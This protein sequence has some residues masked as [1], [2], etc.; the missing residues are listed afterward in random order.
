MEAFGLLPMS[1]D[2]LFDLSLNFNEADSDQAIDY[3]ICPNCHIHM[4]VRINQYICERCGLL[5]ENIEVADHTSS[6]SDNSYSMVASGIRCIGTNAYRYH[7]ILRSSS[8]SAESNREA[9]LSSVLFNF[10]SNKN[11]IIPKEVLLSVADQYRYIVQSGT[12]ARGT[13]FRAML[14]SLT[15][16]EC[17]RR[18]FGFKP[19][20]IYTW[21]EIDP[22]TYSKGDKKIRELLDYG[23]LDVDLREI[24]AEESYAYTYLT[25]MNM[26]ELHTAFIIE[27][28]Q[29]VVKDKLI[30]PNAK[31]STRALS[32]INFFMIATQHPMTSAEFEKQFNCNFGSIRTLTIDM[33]QRFEHIKHIFLKHEIP[34][35]GIDNQ[36][37]R[38]HK[39][40]PK[41]GTRI[42]V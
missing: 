36:S 2:S 42:E 15:Y 9:L 13:I 20:D 19:C 34:F 17:L 33:I 18:H 3:S 40:K 27:L 6:I 41:K 25:A 39:R 11:I 12:I 16:Y 22:S 10:R 30:N 8:N 32:I 23:Q 31:S 7:A 24:N 4:F 14:A 38:V 1:A 5:K 35:Q 37:K 21:F 28:L 29:K 26:C